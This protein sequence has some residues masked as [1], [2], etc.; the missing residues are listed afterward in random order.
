MATVPGHG[1][2][3]GVTDFL[4]ELLELRERKVL[5][6]AWPVNPWE[7]RL[8]W[9]VSQCSTSLRKQIIHGCRN[10]CRNLVEM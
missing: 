6:L 3:D 4:G 1:A 2:D 5:K 8:V 7:Q 10:D 9:I